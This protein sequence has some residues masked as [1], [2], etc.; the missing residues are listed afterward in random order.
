MEY[1]GGFKDTFLRTKEKYKN[2]SNNLDILQEAIQSIEIKEQTLKKKQPKHILFND[3]LADLEFQKA[4]NVEK[5]VFLIKLRDGCVLK[6]YQD[7]R[8]LHGQTLSLLR[9]IE[10]LHLENTN[11]EFL[12]ES[13]N[14]SSGFT[15]GF[16]DDDPSP[17]SSNLDE[18]DNEHTVF[19]VSLQS[20]SKSQSQKT[21]NEP[22]KL[23]SRRPS[24]S[25]STISTTATEEIITFRSI[26]H[27]MSTI[28]DHLHLI[29]SSLEG[30]LETI[31]VAQ[32]DLEEGYEIGSYHIRLVQQYQT[33]DIQYKSLIQITS[34]VLFYHLRRAIQLDLD[35]Q[36]FL[37][38]NYRSRRSKEEHQLSRSTTEH[39]ILKVNISENGHVVPNTN[40]NDSSS[41]SISNSRTISGNYSSNETSGRSSDLSLSIS[42]SGIINGER[43]EEHGRTREREGERDRPEEW[44]ASRGGDNAE[45]LGRQSDVLSMASHE[46][47]RD[48]QHDERIVC[49]SSNSNLYD[50]GN[51]ELRPISISGGLEERSADIYGSIESYIGICDD[52]IS[53]PESPRTTG[54]TP[55]SNHFLGEIPQLIESRV[56]E[57]P[58]RP[59]TLSGIDEESSGGIRPSSGDE[60]PY[61]RIYRESVQSRIQRYE[62]RQTGNLRND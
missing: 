3:A 49:S 41:N 50:N 52:S 18:N 5:H 44:L 10:S 17:S 21:D 19:E 30:Y 34:Q 1:P 56:G 55:I 28:F 12:G 37:E 16:G 38:S 39:T 32:N 35:V 47:S 13:L 22:Q 57:T 14:T 58:Q 15:S 27:W 60:S 24:T 20:L 11:R 42:S 46:I 40:S 29:Q 6:Y 8:R 59:P 31:H 62:D 54:T 7:L 33:L 36:Y 53:I 25:A 45:V 23:N 4:M 9:Q 26:Y 2:I 61:S 51:S 48:V 43:Q